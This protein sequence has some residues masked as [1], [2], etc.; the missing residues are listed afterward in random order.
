LFGW[1]YFDRFNEIAK[2][3]LEPIGVIAIDSGKSIKKRKEID[4]YLSFTADAYYLHYCNLGHN[5]IPEYIMTTILHLIVV[6]EKTK[7]MESIFDFTFFLRW[8]D[9]DFVESSMIG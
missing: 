5:M 2:E 6:K 7:K 9:V 4:I 8:I 3:L 1:N